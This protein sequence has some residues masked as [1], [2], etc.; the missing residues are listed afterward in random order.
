MRYSKYQLHRNYEAVEHFFGVAC[1]LLSAL[2]VLDY[3][4]MIRW[5]WLLLF[6]LACGHYMLYYYDIFPRIKYRPF[7][8]GLFVF[9]VGL[10]WPLWCVL[11]LGKGKVSR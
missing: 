9:G 8:K 5:A 11:Q 7:V 6:W 4:G 3:L 10:L 2:S 1:P